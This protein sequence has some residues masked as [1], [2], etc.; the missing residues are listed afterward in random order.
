MNM[1]TIEHRVPQRENVTRQIFEEEILAAG[2]PVVLKGLVTH[3]PVVHAARQS[4]QMLGAYLKHH[5]SGAPVETFVGQPQ[6]KGRYFYNE[7][8]SGFN[9]EKGKTALSHIVDQLLLT[10]DGP[11]PLM[12]YAGSAPTSEAAPGFARD[13]IMPLLNPGIEPRLWLGNT[14]RVAAHY[15]NSRNVACCLA[16]TRRFTLFP[17]DQIGNLYIGP[18]DFTMAGPPASMVD[19]DA[20]D[21]DCHPKFRAAEK[22]GMVAELEPGDAIYIPSLWWH[23][24]EADG[25]FNLLANYWWMPSGSGPCFESMLLA[26]VG[27]RDQPDP[28]KQAWRSFF[29]H[30]VFNQ[31]ATGVSNHLPPQRRTVLGPKSNHRDSQIMDFLRNRLFG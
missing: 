3:W 8:M 10:A 11:P 23:H 15:D 16:G 14:S 5:D 6:M 26:I 9:Y 30:Y 2:Q 1:V 19:F 25:P 27:L 24:V 20:P 4:N 13:N 22:A 7:D 28:E 29:E 31:H 18:L 12:I 21:Y 17:P